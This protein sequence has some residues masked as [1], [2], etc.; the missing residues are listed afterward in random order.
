MQGNTEA[1]FH[2]GVMH[3]N[4][5]GV[6]RNVMQAQYF[7]SMTSK[8]VRLLPRRLLTNR[9]VDEWPHSCAGSPQ[10][11][12]CGMQWFN[13]NAARCLLFWRQ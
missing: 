7:F 6:P 4:G 8:T 3:L 11:W 13:L 12:R 9:G 10:N 2:L 5:W 1:W